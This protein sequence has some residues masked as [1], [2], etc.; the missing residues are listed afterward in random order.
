MTRVTFLKKMILFELSEDF[1]LMKNKTLIILSTH[2][3][4]AR[5]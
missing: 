2:H 5:T 1:V 3:N 4:Y